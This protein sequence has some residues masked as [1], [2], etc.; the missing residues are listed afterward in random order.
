MTTIEQRTGADPQ[1]QADQ[2]AV[3]RQWLEGIPADPAVL[4]RVEERSQRATAEIRRIHG[5][6]DVDALLREVRDES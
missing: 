2:E 5:T 4:R 1:E 3:M 6:I